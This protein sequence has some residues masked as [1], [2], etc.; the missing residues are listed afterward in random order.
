LGRVVDIELA[1]EGELSMYVCGPTV[2]DA[3]H[4]G[5]GRSALVYDVLRRYLQATGLRVRHVSNVTDVDD[6]IIERAARE[7]TT[8]KEVAL[9]WEQKW[10]EACDAL[11]VLRPTVVPHA[12]EYVADMVEWVRQLVQEGSAYVAED[13]VYL[14]TEAVPGYG[15]LALQP[16]ETLKAG[17]RVATDEAKHNPLD[18]ALWKLSNEE[19]LWESPWGRGRPGWHTECVVMSLD[20][21]GEGFDLHGGG[22]DL[23][24]PHHENERAQAVALHKHFARHWIHHGMVE[25][26]GEKM[27]KSLGNFTT[28]S[29]LLEAHDPRAFRLLVLRSHYRSPLEVNAEAIGHAESAL[30]RLDALVRRVPQASFAQA[31]LPAASGAQPPSGP[32]ERFSAGLANDLDTPSAT[33]CL[34][35]T[36]RDAN[37]ALDEGDSERG[38]ALAQAAVSMARS[39]GL[40]PAGA[41]PVDERAK[42]LLERRAEA[43]AAKDFQAADVLREQIEALGWAVEDGPGGST[44]RKL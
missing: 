38:L 22:L 3:P 16:L 33:A 4:L 37:V 24:F 7:A 5:H 26:G 14:S 8:A 35:E 15:L 10:W 13:G 34:F 6:K 42:E 17:A 31:V 39:V 1:R 29:E 23:R 43:R 36:I 44:L 25:V 2:Y 18:F 11:G 21:L 19:P 20:I 12:T 40:E 30:G 9:Y 32:L 28:L 41:Q 27:S